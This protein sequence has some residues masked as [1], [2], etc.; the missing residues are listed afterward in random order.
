MNKAENNKPKS[1]YSSGSG[2]MPQKKI[3][4]NF[5]IRK[6]THQSIPHRHFEIEGEAFMLASHGEAEPKLVNEA[7]SSSAKEE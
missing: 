7:L 2:S 6:S 5:Q 1:L 3:S 4:Q